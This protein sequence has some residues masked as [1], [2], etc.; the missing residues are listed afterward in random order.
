MR[1]TEDF[2]AD[3]LF[4]VATA[5]YQIEG[6][7]NEDGRVPSHWDTFSHRPGAVLNGDTGDIACD[8]YHRYADDIRLIKDLGVTSYR[9]SIAWP[10]IQPG[11]GKTNPHGLAFYHRVLDELDRHGIIPAVTFY[12]WDLPMWAADRGGWLNRDVAEY[13][14]DYAAI[15]FQEFGR[16][17][18]FWITHNEPWCSAFL[19]YALGEHAPGHRNWRD[20]VIASHHLLLS[21]GKAVNTFRS[22]GVEGQ[23][24]ITLNL[25]VADP[26]SDQARDRDAAHRADGY[27][28]RW[29]LDPIFRG[30]YPADMLDVFR[31]TVGSYDFM[32]PEDAAVIRAPLD[33]LGVNYYTRSLVFDKPGDGPLNVGTVQ[34]KPSEST[35]MGWEIHP[36]SLYR[37]LTRLEREYTQ[38]LPLYITENG[39]AFDDHLGVDGQVHDDRRIAYLQQHVAAA[40]RF[41][42]AGGTLKGYYVWSLLDNF[43]WAFGYSK[44]FGLIYVDFPTQT[45]ILKDSAHW[46]RE[47][48]QRP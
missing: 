24:G 5:A 47:L 29:F 10:R 36:E 16:R 17:V 43:E 30:Q 4:G 40:R 32:H 23:I 48:I 12:H 15:L 21:H 20:A 9:F 35:A 42:Q 25:T 1:H 39:A 2:P 7:V 34:P 46:Y 13:F 38:G 45:R 41:L 14:N 27:A 26:A 22:L 33:F 11:P 44:R 6:A 8:H 18:P 3:F 31:P 19:G 37:L 28:N